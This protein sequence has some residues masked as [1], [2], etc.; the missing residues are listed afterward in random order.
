MDNQP[1]PS[2]GT[3]RPIYVP[4]DGRS[5][6]VRPGR[7]YFSLQ[8]YSAQAAF[9]G[10][11]WEQAKRLV[12]TSQVNL[13]HPVLDN[14][15]LRA[16][17]RS[18]EVRKGRAEQLGLSPNLI[19]LTPAV[20]THLSISIEFIVD[21]AN[22]LGALSS[23]INDDSFAA[24]ISLAPG[25]AIAAKTIGGLAQKIIQAFIPTEEREPILQFTGDFNL[26]GEGLRDGYYV[27][28]GTRDEHNPIPTAL[29]NLEVL[30]GELLADGKRVT[31]L[32]YVILDVRRSPARTRELNDQALWEAKLRE[33]EGSAQL[34]ASDPFTIDEKR[35]HA[36]EHCKKLLQE[37]HALLLADPNY[38]PREAGN[39]FR[40]AYKNCIEQI[41]GEPENRLVRG[42]IVPA[43]RHWDL[44]AQAER[45]DLG[46]PPDENLDTAL[47]EYTEDIFEARRDRADKHFDAF[48]RLDAPEKVSPEQKFTVTVGFRT[49]P[50]PDLLVSQQIHIPN[51]PPDAE[52]LV[53][54]I[55][56]GAKVLN[57]N[58]RHLP[59][60]LYAQATFTCQATPGSSFAKLSA[61]YIYDDQVAGMAQRGIIVT[62]D[63]AA[64]VPAEVKARTR[65]NPCRMSL[66]APDSRTDLQILISQSGQDRLHWTFIAARPEIKLGPIETTLPNA[67]EFAADLLAD[68]KAQ[69][70]TG[71]WAARSLENKGQRIAEKMPPEFFDVLQRV[72]DEIGQRRPTILL[73]T[74]ELYVPWELARLE[75]PLDP[76]LPHYLGAQTLISRWLLNEKVVY[77]PPSILDIQRI[78]AVAS[79]Y[80]WSHLRELPESLNEQRTLLARFGAIPVE[81]TEAGLTPLITDDKTPGHLIHFAIHGMSDPEANHQALLL[82]DRKTLTPGALAGSYKCGQTPT[83]AFVFLNACQVGTAGSSLG[84]AAGFP[85]DVIR[86]GALG[87]VAPLWEVDDAVSRAFA[88]AFYEAALNDGTTL[89]VVMQEQR[90]GYTGG[91]S[92]TPLAYIYYGHPALKLRYQNNK[93]SGVR[94]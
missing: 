5:Q 93:A 44:D 2:I 41:A 69:N 3:T 6:P 45:V 82:A 62:A 70:L 57:G 25:A 30:N 68:L 12:V 29:P 72:Q 71:P 43:D 92:L 21:K 50:D 78:T 40:A 58:Q 20:M 19:T 27:I 77:P 86:G 1:Y 7:D 74:D 76:D 52:F 51:P 22:R 32:S 91:G 26:H 81:A 48:P 23:L 53:M 65:S 16:I 59:L 10:S 75:E 47:D 15:G 80:R 18:R 84:Q 38:L 55:A 89:G 88:E 83:F 39:I 42:T 73:F 46:I 36:W 9:T 24:A 56:D 34:I 66:P 67:R 90:C 49:E 85:G 33:A 61:Y 64:L 14:E 79:P 37:A 11:L 13:H 4:R 60:D 63:K 54:L 17:Q 28:L 31:Q 94:E 87:F 35:Q 8:I